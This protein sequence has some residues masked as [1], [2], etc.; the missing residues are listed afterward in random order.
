MNQKELNDYKKMI[1]KFKKFFSKRKIEKI[2]T[3]I[4]KLSKKKQNNHFISKH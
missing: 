3:E 1:Y 2:R 4:I